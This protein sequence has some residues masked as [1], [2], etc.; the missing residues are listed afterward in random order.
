MIQ[1]DE[2]YADPSH[3]RALT[4]SHKTLSLGKMNGIITWG[5]SGAQNSSRFHGNPS[6]SC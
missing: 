3:K 1:P 4:V 5:I 6:D 2:F